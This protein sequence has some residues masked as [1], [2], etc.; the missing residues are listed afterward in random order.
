MFNRLAEINRRPR[1]FECYTAADLWTNGHTSQKMLEY[2]LNE[3]IDVSSRNI[4]FINRSAAWIMDH[5]RLDN[6]SAVMDFGCGPGLYTL[7]FARGGIKTTG[8]DFSRRSVE[9]AV[10]AAADEHLQ[11]DYIT[12]NYL[13]YDSSKKFDLITMIM[14]DYCALSPA[15][16]K[17]M[18]DKFRKLLKPGGS[19]LLDV[20]T[21]E[22]Y[23]KREEAAVY[24]RKQLSGFW[25]PHDYYTF[26]NTFKYDSEKVVLDKYTII[27]K[28]GTRVVYNWLQYFD[29]VS[30]TKEFEE[31]GLKIAEV[32]SNVAGAEYAHDA[33]EMAVAAKVI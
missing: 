1:P 25:S 9:Y 20:Y 30:L 26:M 19:V 23:S 32:F 31:N 29:L 11:I 3:S 6:N 4:D 15:Q 10:R 7:R 17:T 24:E 2:H 27:E 8:I 18:L 14:C 33:P 22:A 5:F 12:G 21:L 16:R 13:E 28:T